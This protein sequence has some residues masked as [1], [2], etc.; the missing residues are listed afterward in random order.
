LKLIKKDIEEA[1]KKGLKEALIERL[2]LNDTRVDGM[3][4]GLSDLLDLPDPVGKGAVIKRPNGLTLLKQKVPLG[5]IGIIYESR[6]NVTSDAA[7]L[8]IK[9]RKQCYSQRWF[10][11]N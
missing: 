11:G 6:P 1:R 4:K 8:C 10:R 9:N 5:V 7:G 3:I 2:M